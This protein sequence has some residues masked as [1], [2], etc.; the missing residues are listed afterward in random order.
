MGLGSLDRRANANG[1]SE[2]AGT[3]ALAHDIT[4]CHSHV[5]SRTGFVRDSR[6]GNPLPMVHAL[7]EVGTVAGLSDGELLERFARHRGDEAELAFAALVSRHGSAVLAICRRVLRDSHAAEDAFQATFLVLVRRASSLRVRDSLGPWL[8]EVARRVAACSRASADRRRVHEGRAR[9]DETIHDPV[10]DD[11]GEIVRDEVHRLPDRYRRPVV[12]CDLEERTYEEVARKLRCPVGTVKS[13]LARG[14]G[15]LKSR[16]IRRGVAPGA[17]AAVGLNAAR[18]SAF[19]IPELLDQITIRAGMRL[20]VGQTTNG[21]VSP[22]VLA[23]A[24]GALKTMALARMKVATVSLIL[25]LVATTSVVVARQGPGDA[26]VVPASR[27]ARQTRHSGNSARTEGLSILDKH[28]ARARNGEDPPTDEEV[29]NRFL[30]TKFSNKRFLVELIGSKTDP[31]K[32]Y[33]LV[34]PAKLVHQHYKCTIYFD[35]HLSK[36]AE[37]FVEVLYLDKDHLVRCSDSSHDHVADKSP[38]LGVSPGSSSASSH[39]QRLADVERKLDIILKKFEE[40][41]GQGAGRTPLGP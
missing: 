23:L 4:Y 30:E 14:R 29:W 27:A 5:G 37:H 1:R 20:A 32:I 35:T 24:E 7:F 39:E 2:K 15:L 12:L 11:L 34:G 10:H 18:S 36:N 19:M 3:L 25:G 17:A 31:C 41:S 40:P 16:L 28:A 21:M 22:S 13:R 33:P 9:D 26:P 6:I 38:L 8:Q